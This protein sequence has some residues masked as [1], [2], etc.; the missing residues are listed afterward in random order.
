M[1]EIL[2]KI[3]IELN[4]HQKLFTSSM[5]C[6]M[7]VNSKYDVYSKLAEL[8]RLGYVTYKECDGAFKGEPEGDINITELGKAKLK[9]PN[10]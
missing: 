6:K 8:K 4:N 5:Y 1:D 9:N 10:N 2:K 7:G 3:L